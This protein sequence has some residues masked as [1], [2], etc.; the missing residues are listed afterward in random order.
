MSTIMAG[1]DWFLG[2]GSTVFVPIIMFVLAMIFGG[3][4]TKSIRS[5]LYIGIGLKALGMV[6]DLSV[7]AMQPVTEGLS[8][9][10]GVDFS[11]IDIGYGNVNVAW[12]G[13]EY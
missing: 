3:E 4:L 2:L 11:T 6:I 9:R 5:A 13:L 8:K 1:V 10:L 12:A 7:S